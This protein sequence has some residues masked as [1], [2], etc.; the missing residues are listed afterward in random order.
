MRGKL[1]SFAGK[2]LS[3]FLFF[4]SFSALQAQRQVVA[5]PAIE[6]ALAENKLAEAEALVQQQ[7]DRFF[8]EKRADSL[9][10]Y[11]FYTGKIEQLRNG[12]ES[13]VKKLTALVN[14]IQTLS[15]PAATLRQTWLEAGEYFGF[16]GKLNLAYNANTEALQQTAAMPGKTPAQLGLIESNLGTFAQRM[17]NIGLSEQHQRRAFQYR[18]SD[19]TTDAESLYV[20][21]NNMGSILYYASK[22]DSALLFFKK[23][24]ETV[25]KTEPTPVNQ[26]YRPA[27]VLNNI[28]GIYSLQ[29]QSTKAIDALKTSILYLK[30]F[31]ASKEPHLKKSSAVS[32]QF[33][34]T[35]NLAGIYKELGNYRQAQDLL[36]HSYEQKKVALDKGDPAIFISQILLG[37]LY[38]AM[39][40]HDKAR[41]FLAEGLEAISKADGDHTFWQADACSTLALLHDER[42]EK[43]QATL[44]Y[45]KADALY[46]ASL[47]GDYD[48]IYLEFISN[49]ALFYA[50]NNNTEKALA[51]SK[52]AYDYIAKT[53]GT[54]TLSASYQL[55]NLSE[56]HQLT[57]NYTQALDYSKK[58][59]LAMNNAIRSGSSLL[60]S[61]KTE[62]KKPKAILQKAK[63]EYALLPAKSKAEL[64]RI[65]G[66]LAE[67]L[68]I[69]ERRKTVLTDAG[70]IGLLLSDQAG[71]LKFMEKITLE[72]YIQSGDV[73]Y[74]HRLMGFHESGLYNRIR[75][76]LDKADTL[77]FAHVPAA[78]QAKEK[79]LK[80]AVAAA[81]EG[82]RSHPE[83]MQAYFKAVEAWETFREG[84]KRDHP[85][86]YHLRYAAIF[87]SLPDLRQR[88]PE[89]TT[90][91][92]YFFSDSSLFALVVDAR[93]ERLLPLSATGLEK[94]LAILSKNAYDLAPTSEA[95][96]T[97]Y[98]QLWAPLEKEVRNKKV[99]IIP[100]G[101]LYSLSFET[102]TPKKISS[103]HDLA[104]NSLLSRHSIAYHYS[105]FL[106]GEKK[107]TPNR[108]A[109]FV[110]F[111]PGFTEQVK[112][113][114]R[115]AVSASALP[116]NSYLSLLPQPFTLDLATK[117]Q[118]LLGGAAFLNEQSTVSSF[119]QNAAH[120]KIIHIGTHAE[121][122]NLHPEYS[123]LIF[124]KT[125]ADENNSLYLP[126]I[127]NCDLSSDLAVLT[128]CE[129]GRPG[130]EDGEGMVSLAHAFHYAG[131]ESMLTGLWKIDEKASAQ[132]MEAFYQNLVAGMSKDEALRQAKLHYLQTAEGR[133][134]SPQYWAGLVIMGDTAPIELK[135]AGKISWRW[136][137]GA[138]IFLLIGSFV[139]LLR[140]KEHK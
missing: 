97:L 53:Q 101:I 32:L 132:L 20:S 62:L 49:A 24:I 140:R 118:R 14:R 31:I 105:L 123:R 84:L 104:T 115:T 66:E 58:A 134:L 54:G 111:A 90:L 22:L 47:Q 125:S 130:F 124:A 93:S 29:G 121:S 4:S 107:T 19:P 7:V 102:L 78:V 116:D 63:A 129:S 100:D 117:A 3:C 55:L 128:A 64:S 27:L 114:Y 48:N 11:I 103:F 95:L 109:S 33:E 60:D 110:A 79:A 96:A 77:R 40:D 65:L 2:L 80:A 119:R 92:R 68:A 36:L 69:I 126:E 34:A 21:Y 43:E 52:K 98:R 120:H 127:Y 26:Y 1:R 35:D 61:V 74:L 5:I 133:A 23:A 113:P 44:Y 70:D 17:G 12:A 18:L 37:Q 6:K 71:L 45:E 89:G 42:G 138:A 75:A 10:H 59:L 8:A 137:V 15:P 87:H 139:I 86:Y 67:A 135:A 131:S 39:K 51:R 122:N 91:V 88:I 99:L 82:D 73:T 30:N 83:K 81:L 136:F 16:A 106:L 28:A 46:E 94:Q 112:G 56:V 85:R 25:K 50:E 13:G 57:G 9:N 72:L 108:Q 76:Q 41:R 38:Y